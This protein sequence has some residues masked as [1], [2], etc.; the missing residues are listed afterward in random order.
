MIRPAAG[1]ADTATK[2]AAL[3]G[4]ARLL[5]PVR[6]ELLRK[7]YIA[8]AAQRLEFDERELARHVRTSNANERTPRPPRDDEPP[9]IDEFV[10]Y[11][12]EEELEPVAPLDAHLSTLVEVLVERPDLLEVVHREQIHHVIGH[13]RLATFIEAAAARWTDEGTP[14]F[15][16][17]IDRLEDLPLKSALTAALVADRGLVLEGLEDVFYDTARSLK[18]RWVLDEMKQVS[19][20]LRSATD[21]DLQI[22]LTERLRNL[23]RWRNSLQQPLSDADGRVAN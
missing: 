15:R 1:R 12:E 18:N 9:P 6:N 2:R 8:D 7:K 4:V 17:A 19:E 16:E 13:E 23:Q 14:T 5:A 3:D 20:E 10:E 11:A 22:A 21:F